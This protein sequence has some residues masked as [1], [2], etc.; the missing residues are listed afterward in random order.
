M[1]R[2]VVHHGRVFVPYKREGWHVPV[3][4]LRSDLGAGRL[5]VGWFA[6]TRSDCGNFVTRESGEMLYFSPDG[7]GYYHDGKTLD[8]QPG[9]F[10]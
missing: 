9:L 6:G 4:V 5:A 10:Q 7:L 8:A 1:S 2:P 3:D